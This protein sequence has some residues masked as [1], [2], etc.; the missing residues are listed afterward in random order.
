M[1][2][3]NCWY[4]AAAGHELEQPWVARRVLGQALVLMRTAAGEVTALADACPHRYLPLSKGRRV[5]DALRCGYH[6][7]EFDATGRCT[8]I[9]GQEK[10][11]AAASV[12]RY[13]A[14]A[15]HGFVWVWLGS[16]ELADERLIPDLHWMTDPGW[17]HSSGYHRFAADYRLMNDN[18]LDLS[19][20]SYVHERTIGNDTE[21]SIAHYPVHVTVEGD[22]LVR[23]HRD[24]NGIT[25]PPL[26]AM[27]LQHEG[28][29]NRWQTAI[30]QIP[31]IHMTDAGVYPVAADPAR[32]FVH[33]ALH[34][35]TPETETSTH[36]FWAVVRNYRIDEPDLTDVMHRGVAA[37]FDEDKEVIEE[38][39]RQLPSGDIRVPGV[40]IQVDEAPGR[41]RRLL[42]AA[43][44]RERE[45]PN[46]VLRPQ[47]L[48]HEGR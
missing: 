25:P 22:G 37:T 43:V 33:H 8:L 24:M 48:L 15:R 20:E 41:A 17:V 19:H 32:A 3:K 14:V 13:P 44:R 26:F 36:Y 9:P 47:P 4:V 29:I 40:A 11:P 30:H 6:G 42:E 46:L 1:W 10:I 7:M 12:Q 45:Q 31:G 27:I 39:Q 38:Q 28:P 16:A 5:G 18:L 21:E 34:L 2:L 35:L 23:A